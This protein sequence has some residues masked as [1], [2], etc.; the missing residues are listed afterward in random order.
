MGILPTKQ[1]MDNDVSVVI[2]VY[3]G[4][5]F[6]GRAIDSVLRQTHPARQIIVVNDGSSDRTLE[7]LEAFGEHVSVITTPN[8]GASSARN[9]GIA[10]CTSSLI[11]FLDADDVWEDDKLERQVRF[12]ARQPDAGLCCC[13]YVVD[14]DG[15]P[16]SHYTYVQQEIQSPVEQ[17][18]RQGLSTLATSNFIG[19]ASAVLVRRSL[20]QRVGVFDTS[21]R[22][23]EDY[24]LWIRCALSAR[25]AVM[26][27]VLLRKIVRGHNLTNDQIDMLQHH[28]NVLDKHARSPAF[29]A[30][31][32]VE[33]DALLG[34][35]RT[36]Y[37]IASLFFEAR[38][39]R[40]SLAYYLTG[41]GTV[42]SGKNLSLF[43][44][45][46]GRKLVRIVTFGTVRARAA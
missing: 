44:Y 25:I 1:A 31:A 21:Y 12:L 27:D 26:P 22:Q 30:L 11:A 19:T 32:H 5:A 42:C 33:R 43:L 34:L 7:V 41:L 20:L 29:R 15:P 2:P 18:G 39:Y 35:A 3:N 46:T 8:R 13:D 16:R 36:R 10:A 6:I 17:W 23:A 28:E 38:R 14:D 37:Q 9:R 4:E 24:D 45:Y 40:D